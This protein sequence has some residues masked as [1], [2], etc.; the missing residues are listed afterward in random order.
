MP[1][2][3][4][5][6]IRKVAGSTL[7]HLRM[8]GRWLEQ[9]GFT[10]G[11][12]V[13]AIYKDSCLTLKTE[14]LKPLENHMPEEHAFTVCV[15]SRLMGNKPKPRTQLF[16]NGFVLRKYGFNLG[17]RVGLTLSPNMIQIS[18]INRFTTECA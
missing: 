12:T 13:T 18:K 16:L 14:A 15:T 6:F 4:E 3:K 17:D 1:K 10:V 7:P 5:L 9:I 11:T 2:F 8:H